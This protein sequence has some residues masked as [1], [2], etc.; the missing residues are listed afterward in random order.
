MNKQGEIY[1][2]ERDGGIMCLENIREKPERNET[3]EG[4]EGT[5]DYLA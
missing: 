2:T 4:T 3:T 5:E 1:C